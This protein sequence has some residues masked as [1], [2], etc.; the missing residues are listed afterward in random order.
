VR[1]ILTFQGAADWL[2]YCRPTTSCTAN[3]QQIKVDGIVA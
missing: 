1:I 2:A 3:Q